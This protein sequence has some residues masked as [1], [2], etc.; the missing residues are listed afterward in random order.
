MAKVLEPVDTVVVG[1]GAAGSLMAAVL[2]EGGKS[3]VVL[4]RG[5]A[6]KMEDLYSSQIWARRLKWGSPHVAD[7]GPDSIW[8]NFNAGHGYGG[9]AIHHYAVWPRYHEDDFEENSRYGRSLDWPFS[10]DELRPYYDQ[11]QEEVGMAGDAEKEIWRPPGDPYPLP[12]VL[13][14]N[15]GQVLARG[16]EAMDMHT[17]PIPMAILTRPYK[18]RPACIWD[19]WCDAGCPIGALANPLAIY[20]PRAQKAGARLQPNAHVTRVMMDKSGKKATGVEYYT[21]EGE[22]FIQP[23]K[24]VVLCAFT[25]ENSRILL[26]SADSNHPNGVGNSSETLGRYLM[27]HPAIGVTGLFD[28]DMQNYLGATG[29]Q[30]LSQDMF[31]KKGDPNGAFGSRQWEIGLALKPNDMLGIGMTRPDIF[32]AKLEAFMQDGARH[33]GSMVGVCEDEPLI[34]N[35]IEL[36]S[37]KDAFGFPLAKVVYEM[38]AEGRKLWQTAAKEGV[39]IFKAAGAREA[40][41]GPPGG[42]HIMGGTIMGKDPASSVL[43]GHGQAHDVDNLFVGGPGVFPTSSSINS[44]FTAKAMAMK[45]ARYMV[46]NWSALSG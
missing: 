9:A 43:N 39:D 28:E 45:S 3:V 2:A 31:D 4:E 14:S 21:P 34:T 1:T 46:D 24:A 37:Q 11:V 42:Q 32:G 7:A 8:F 18:G 10:Y 29:G 20:L 27:A 19:G 26:N 17:A 25:V 16:F 6:R 5:K 41:H 38:S 44:T 33:M 13:V 22:A 12:P 15:H 30:L 35:R 23:A 36:S 40:W